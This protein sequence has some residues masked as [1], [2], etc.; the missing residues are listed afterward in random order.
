M[1]LDL[2]S[3]YARTVCLFLNQI[4]WVILMCFN[5]LFLQL[6]PPAVRSALTLF[7]SPLYCVWWSFS[8]SV[9]VPPRLKTPSESSQQTFKAV[10]ST[11]KQ[12]RWRTKHLSF[13]SW[14]KPCHQVY[15][16]CLG[17]YFK[18]RGYAFPLLCFCRVFMNFMRPLISATEWRTCSHTL[19]FSIPTHRLVKLLLCFQAFTG[20]PENDVSLKH[21]TGD[22]QSFLQV[23][24]LF[25]ADPS[26][27]VHAYSEVGFILM[28]RLTYPCLKL[29][30]PCRHLQIDGHFI[31]NWQIRG[32]VPLHLASLLKFISPGSL[33]S[34]YS[35][36]TPGRGKLRAIPAWVVQ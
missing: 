36:C 33:R 14:S 11:R 22:F 3:Y 29:R 6:S 27:S 25:M 26:P 32:W 16:Y 19:V 31:S 1:Q 4:S 28:S 2:V 15:L 34:R 35:T 8:N 5:E 20:C 9:A 18:I 23:C 10:V 21:Q 7:F 12:S 13:V 17:F 30:Q 24:C